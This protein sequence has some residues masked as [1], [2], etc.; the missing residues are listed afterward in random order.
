MRAAENG[1]TATVNAL[2]GTYNANVDAVDQ[3]GKTALVHAAERG[4]TDTVKALRA[5]RA[6]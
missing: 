3:K 5:L 1:R 2:A 4:H 6:P